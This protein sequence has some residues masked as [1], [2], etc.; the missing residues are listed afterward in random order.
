MSF[1]ELDLRTA[2]RHLAF[3]MFHFRLYAKM[4]EDRSQTYTHQAYFQAVIYALLLHFR[5][6][7]HFFYGEPK[8]NDCC[9]EHFRVLP[10][11]ETAF[12]PSIHVR[13]KWEEEVRMHL[14]KRLAHFTDTRWNGMQPSMD[15]YAAHFGEITKLLDAFEMALPGDVK[16][17]FE[18][19]IQSWNKQYSLMPGKRS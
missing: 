10:G 15:Y 8:H 13:P 3:D 2:A 17:D 12:P 4:Y 1:T 18:E 9:A 16:R 6:L 7:L 14:N 19:K 5:L 11:F